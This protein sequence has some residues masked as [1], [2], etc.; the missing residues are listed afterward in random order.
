MQWKSLS[1]I[2][3]PVVL[4]SGSPRRQ[5]LFKYIFSQFEVVTTDAELE[6]SSGDAADFV[7][8]NAKYKAER[9]L[10]ENEESL[11]H[12]TLFTFDTVVS[13]ENQLL[14][15]PN[16]I[17][18]AREMLQVLCGKSHQ[19]STSYFV[20]KIEDHEE[21]LSGY[22]STNVKFANYDM[23]HLDAYLAT[24]ESLDKAGAYGIQGFGRL[25]VEAIDG[26]YYNVVG[27]PVAA[28]FYDLKGL[29]K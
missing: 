19:V 7:L 1:L 26:C 29:N 22:V 17:P 18:D 6:Q 2:D 25:L 16:S 15:K 23:E 12:G 11:T 14:G 9:I 13:I 3:R 8:R 5:S 24:G 28:L 10:S 4:G 27:L 20:C 21:L